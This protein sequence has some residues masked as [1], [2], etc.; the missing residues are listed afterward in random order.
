MA[1]CEKFL[2]RVR[3]ANEELWPEQAFEEQGWEPGPGSEWTLR[4]R[5]EKAKW[6]LPQPSPS[7]ELPVCASALFLMKEKPSLTMLGK[8][9][10]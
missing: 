7:L 8:R 2:R 3:S 10:S 6:G 4:A 1:T 9:S 5:K